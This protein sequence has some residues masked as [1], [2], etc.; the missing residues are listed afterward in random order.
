MASAKVG[1]KTTVSGVMNKAELSEFDVSAH[2]ANRD[3][4]NHGQFSNRR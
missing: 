1:T 3:D 4:G 2:A